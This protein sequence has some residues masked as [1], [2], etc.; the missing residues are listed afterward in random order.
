MVGGAP[1]AAPADEDEVEA[2]VRAALDDDP[3]AGPRQVAELRGGVARR[4]PA[5]RLRGRPARAREHRSRR[6]GH[7]GRRL[8]APVRYRR[9]PPTT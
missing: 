8:R 7:V 5:A 3:S 4:A 6:R 1:A 2:A 9:C